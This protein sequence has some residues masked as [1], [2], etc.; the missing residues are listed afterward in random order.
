MAESKENPARSLEGTRADLPEPRGCAVAPGREP[1]RGLRC[2]PGPGDTVETYD[3]GSDAWTSHDA[4]EG[5]R[6]RLRAWIAKG[7]VA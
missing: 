1:L 5:Q 3:E 4:N 2:R 7:Y 6:E